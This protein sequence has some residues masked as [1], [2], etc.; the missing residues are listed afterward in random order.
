[1]KAGAAAQ[2]AHEPDVAAAT[3]RSRRSFQAET[4]GQYRRRV[5]QAIEIK[6]GSEMLGDVAFPGRNDATPG[7]RPAFHGI[8]PARSPRADYSSHAE[9]CESSVWGLR[10]VLG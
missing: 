6:G 2:L 5:R 3:G 7:L 1:M 8:R 9:L 10:R 4:P